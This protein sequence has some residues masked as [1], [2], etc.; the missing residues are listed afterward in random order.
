M[1]WIY[2]IHADMTLLGNYETNAFLMPNIIICIIDFYWPGVSKPKIER[3]IRCYTNLNSGPEHRLEKKL[4][5]CCLRFLGTVGKNLM[6]KTHENE[7]S[8]IPKTIFWFEAP[9]C[10]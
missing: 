7:N 10:M 5:P 6:K 4:I 1:L 2:F 3:F 8:L 9:Q